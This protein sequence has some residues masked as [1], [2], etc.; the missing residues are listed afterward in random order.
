MRNLSLSEKGNHQLIACGACEDTVRLLGS[1]A[2]CKTDALVEQ[3]L[4]ALANVRNCC[5]IRTK[6]TR[7]L[8]AYGLAVLCT[9]RA[10]QCALSSAI[11]VLL[12]LSLTGMGSGASRQQSR[13]LQR[14]GKR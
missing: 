1:R 7:G 13:D 12:P 11:V 5:F 4:S 10:W 6:I 8:I 9:F 3:G 2:L 14:R